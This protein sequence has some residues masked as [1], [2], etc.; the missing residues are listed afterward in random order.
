[1]CNGTEG[2]TNTN[3]YHTLIKQAIDNYPNILIDMPDFIK[4]LNIP[5]LGRRI[6]KRIEE[7]ISFLN[8]IIH[9]DDNKLFSS[10]V[11]KS[12]V[13][14]DK[15]NRKKLEMMRDLWI[16]N[17]R[18]NH[19]DE[20]KTKE[21]REFKVALTGAVSLPRS[22]WFKEMAKHGVEKVSVGKNCN[23]LICNGESSSS[24]YKKAKDLCIP[25][26]TEEAF[27]EILNNENV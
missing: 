18:F 10:D 7:T 15:F 12:T 4:M 24:S 8:F 17:F 3:H 27:M 20:E 14:N 23:Y 19:C 16:E 13:L 22:K 21:M 1:M 26:V 11:F 25:I 6:G 2:F 5:T 9:I